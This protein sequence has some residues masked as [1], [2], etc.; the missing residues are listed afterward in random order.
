VASSIL[1]PQLLD[2]TMQNLGNQKLCTLGSSYYVLD[3]LQT[4]EIK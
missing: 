3:M 4:E 2:I 1:D